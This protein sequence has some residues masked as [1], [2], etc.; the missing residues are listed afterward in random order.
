M[1]E[2]HILLLKKNVGE[3]RKNL[4][5]LFS[6]KSLRAFDK[7]VNLNV[8]Q[9]FALGEYHFGF[10]D[11][12][13]TANWRQKVS[14]A[15]YGAYSVSK[16][17][18]LKTNGSYSTESRDHEKVSELP[19]DFPNRATYANKLPLLRD[20]RNLCDYDHTAVVVDL[21]ETLPDTLTL[22]R[23]FIGDARTYLRNKGV[24]V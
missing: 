8:K 12:L 9:L 7:E 21:V 14:R 1:R 17:V 22:V 11:A 4:L 23:D 15:Y 2:P 18:R 10:A 24:R 19:A 5:N 13:S 20:D 6:A 3:L 16:A